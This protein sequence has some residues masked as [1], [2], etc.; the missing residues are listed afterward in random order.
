MHS[1]LLRMSTRVVQPDDAVFSALNVQDDSK[2]LSG[3]P[4]PI[5]FKPEKKFLLQYENATQKV[6]VTFE[7]NTAEC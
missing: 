5:I 7:I 3:F 2:F 4:W 6:F 1:R